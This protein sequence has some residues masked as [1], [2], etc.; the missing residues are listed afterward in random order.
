MDLQSQQIEL[1]R[2][3][4]RG[5]R[6]CL[7]QLAQQA[8]GR[9]KTYVFRLTQQEDLTQEIVQES[10]LEMFKVIGKLRRADR[11]WPWLYGIATNKLRR[12]YRTEKT[13]RKAA[14]SS[15]RDRMTL[16]ERQDGF[17]NLVGE[18]LKQ[19]VS[20]AMKKLRTRHR[21]ILIMRCYD[22]MSYTEIAE[23]MGCSEFSTRMLFMRAKRA[24]QKELS[25]NG[26]GKGSLLA[27]LVLFGKITAPSKAVAA[28]ISVT[29][30]TMD[31]GLIAGI[32]GLATT[33]TAIILTTAGALTV[34]TVAVTTLPPRHGVEGPHPS[35]TISQD[36]GQA[37]ETNQEYRY[38][39]P[40]GPTG[41]VMIRAQSGSVGENSYWQVLQNERGNYYFH[42]NKVYINNYRM[43]ADDLNVTKIPTDDPELTNYIC[44]VEGS[45]N[46]V[47]PV[48]AKGEG[49]LVIAVRDET[50]D[51][52]RP[53][54]IR[55]YN[56][57]EEDYFQADWPATAKVIDNRDQMHER[58]WTFFRISG[59]IHGVTVTGSGRIP[60]VYFTSLQYRPWL[61]LQV[62][63][64][65]IVDTYDSAYTYSSPQEPLG[66]YK[67]GS[68]FKGLGRPWMGLHTIDTVRRDAAEQRIPFDTTHTQ[69]SRYASVELVRNDIR[70]IYKI[71]LEKDVIDEI[72]FYNNQ[73][74]I[75]NL[76][77]SYLQSV[78]DNIEFTVPGRP[79]Q[80]SVA[81]SSSG[82]LWLVQLMEDSL[83]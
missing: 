66:N 75:G 53:W 48:T 69:G 13:Q 26:F 83:E 73:E 17:E 40:L 51:G 10:L 7:E 24:L 16:K 34:G 82:L 42:N 81:K 20:G 9:L 74:I 2:G 29:K 70:M 62:G 55:H 67:G 6:E 33:K 76:K 28:Q 41:P 18:E 23:S 43:Y 35:M 1:I 72:T 11:F 59:Q 22:D 36:V 80:Q 3:A 79:R 77:F 19:I 39:F 47:A 21:A 56:E 38:Y 5:E 31:V 68:F 15:I 63:S 44:Q 50:T 58:G 25:R 61:K 52:N 4:Q 71:D 54:V 46:T 49:L 65:T 32:A 60:F 8:R 57:L 14:V 64:L 27:A 78:Q 45:V 37:A 30:A 12:Y